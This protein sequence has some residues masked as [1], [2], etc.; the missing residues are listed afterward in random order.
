[1][2]IPKLKIYG[3]RKPCSDG[4]A[5]AEQHFATIET[6]VAPAKWVPW[7]GQFNWRFTERYPSQLLI[8]KLAWQISALQAIDILLMAGRLP[9]IGT[10]YRQLDEIEEDIAFISLALVFDTW[11]P[12]HEAYSDYFWSEDGPRGPSVRRK[13]IRN[14]VH[15]ISGQTDVAAANHM[16]RLLHGVYSDFVH[17]RSAPIMGIMKGPPPRFDLSSIR[18]E[19]ARAPY[20]GQHPAYFYRGLVSC[21]MIAKAILPDERNIDIFDDAKAFENA[22]ASLLFSEDKRASR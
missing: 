18:D 9:E 2:I 21:S 22:Y 17:A 3:N 13:T 1:M 4:L 5:R 20:D 8:Q 11:T 12:D 10:L 6:Y 16:G 7:D 14:F 15:S 19:S